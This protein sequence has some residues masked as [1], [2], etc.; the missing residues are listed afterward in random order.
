MI[1]LLAT[2]GLALPAAASNWPQWRGP[3]G[4][5]VSPEANVPL[6]WGAG[7]TVAWTCPLPDGASTP[8]VWGDAV[9][10]TGQDGEKLLLFRIDRDT[11]RVVWTQQVGT[12]KV[13]ASVRGAKRGEPGFMRVHKLYT[14]ANPSPVTD[15]TV[16][17]AHFGTGDLAAYDFAGNQLWAHNLERENG[18]Y[19]TW[20]G[21]SNSPVIVGDLVVSACMQD[22]LADL[23]GQTPVASY[24]VAHDKRTGA[25][26]W[27]SRR[28]TAARAEECDS[29]TTPLLR[30]VNGRQELIVMGGNQ[31]D[32]YDPL[33]GQQRWSVTGLDGGRTITGPTVGGGLVYATRGMRK[34]LVAVKADGT[35]RLPPE[36][37]VWQQEQGT[38]D[39]P[40]PVYHDGLLFW[41]TDNGFANCVD[42]ATGKLHWK[43]RL[44]GEY[45]ASPLVAAGRVYFLNLTG[46]C[47]VVAAA[48]AFEKLADNQLDADTIASPAVADGRL[49]L[50]GRKA[51]FCI[52]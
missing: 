28:D 9:F 29:Y 25:Q 40:T 10:A 6:T 34:N 32:A 35:G 27:K 20:W 37:V 45:K 46:R 51:L 33:T 24:L 7:Q 30:T 5:S 41:V 17:I 16:V 1:P 22:S 52:R 43:E 48:P 39:S 23:P 11:G 49:Y 19:T 2:C 38:P 36:A 26:R 8:A 4:D 31:L 3:T 44:P 18:T 14:L 13:P 12:G 47:K 15:G 21:H 50:R 42:A